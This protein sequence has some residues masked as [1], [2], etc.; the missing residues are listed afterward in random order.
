MFAE[1]VVYVAQRPCSQRNGVGYFWTKDSRT[2]PDVPSGSTTKA[3]ACDETISAA[4]IARRPSGLVPLTQCSLLELAIRLENVRMACHFYVG[5]WD[6]LSAQSFSILRAPAPMFSHFAHAK[7]RIQRTFAVFN[8][9]FKCE[10]LFS[11][12]NVPECFK[13]RMALAP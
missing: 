10:T 3:C 1:W 2:Y 4:S 7:N 11:P 9:T 6:V 13:C 5:N 8:A 12:L